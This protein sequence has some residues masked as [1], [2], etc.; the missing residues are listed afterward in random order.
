MISEKSST[1][2]VKIFYFGKKFEKFSKNFQNFRK[3]NLKPFCREFFAD[4]FDILFDRFPM[5][6]TV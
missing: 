3:K 5:F 4:H 2:K 6:E 1:K